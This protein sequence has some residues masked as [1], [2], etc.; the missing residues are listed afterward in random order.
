MARI[1]NGMACKG[2]VYSLLLFKL[3][4]MYF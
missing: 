1:V 3:S 4:G 2:N